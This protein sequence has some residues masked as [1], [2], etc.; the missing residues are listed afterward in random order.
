SR[1]PG[2]GA[3]YSALQAARL[4]AR[5]KIVTRGV[6]AE[7][8]QLLAPYRD[9]LELEV[10]S[11]SHTTTL[12]TIGTAGA[13]TQRV[14]AWAGPMEAQEV[15]TAILHLAP[16]ARETTPTWRGRAQFVGLT[17]QGLVRTWPRLGAAIT[18]RTLAPAQLPEP[19]DAIVISEVERHSCAWL[20]AAAERAAAITPHNEASADP[21]RGTILAITAGA[22]ATVLYAPGAGSE[23]LPVPRIERFVDDLGAGDVFAAAFFVALRRGDTPG[24]AA[25]FGKAA[26]A[27]RIAGAGPDAVGESAAIEARLRALA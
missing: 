7:I 2:G 15:D 13:R 1:R 18:Q 27:I 10:S 14:L 6:P 11:A 3:F 21:A 23:R 16:V 17:P 20:I 26:A 9:E 19:C 22:D 4:G 5:A 12:E 8:D 25:A 24:E